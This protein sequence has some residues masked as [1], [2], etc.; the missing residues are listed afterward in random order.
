MRRGEEAY[1]DV[2]G[3]L[4]SNTPPHSDTVTIVNTHHTHKHLTD[5]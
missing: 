4:K 1:C 5:L 3:V 2:Q